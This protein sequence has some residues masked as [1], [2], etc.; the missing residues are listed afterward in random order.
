LCRNI[1]FFNNNAPYKGLISGFYR[2]KK[3]PNIDESYRTIVE[4]GRLCAD[5]NTA[6]ENW[7]KVTKAAQWENWQDLRPSCRH[8]K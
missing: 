4:S 8:E 3:N 7:Y 2:Q 5:A 1:N 6:L